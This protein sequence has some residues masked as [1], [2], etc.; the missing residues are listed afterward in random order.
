MQ[1]ITIKTPKWRPAPSV[2]INE[3]YR[4]DME[5]TISYK[6]QIGEKPYPYH[7]YIEWERLKN[8]I[9]IQFKPNMPKV[10]IVPISMLRV[11]N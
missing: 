5:I 1:K 7:Y 6:N 10:R 8:Y 3:K 2:G 11:L 4:D 9:P